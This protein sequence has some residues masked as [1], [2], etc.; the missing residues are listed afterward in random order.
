MKTWSETLN[1]GYLLETARDEWYVH[2]CFCEYLQWS[3]GS[4]F[5]FG[6]IIFYGTKMNSLAFNWNILLL[7]QIDLLSP[8]NRSGIG[9]H[10][11]HQNARCWPFFCWWGHKETKFKLVC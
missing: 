1:W 11:Y 9:A 8:D 2:L 7:W 10:K 5:S 4:I 6:G 3:N